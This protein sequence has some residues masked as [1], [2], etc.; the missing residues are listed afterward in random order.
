MDKLVIIIIVAVV[1]I[2]LYLI[3][4]A[5]VGGVGWKLLKNK[6]DDQSKTPLLSD[7]AKL[8]NYVMVLAQEYKICSL[9]L[10]R[11]GNEP[12]D[13]KDHHDK[14]QELLSDYESYE[15][16]LQ[17]YNELKD[18]LIKN[19]RPITD[20]EEDNDYDKIYRETENSMMDDDPEYEYVTTLY[21]KRHHH[22]HHHHHHHDA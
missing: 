21:A 1:V 20:K 3:V 18:Y 15:D 19:V 10:K 11:L 9:K 4:L 16:R 22:H 5:A 6:N 8:G 12:V 7:D 13:F 14:A 2:A 17:K